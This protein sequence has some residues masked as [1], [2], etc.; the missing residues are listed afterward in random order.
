MDPTIPAGGRPRRTEA[1]EISRRDAVYTAIARA[2]G[3]HVQHIAR[4]TGL[5][6]RG[7]L[8][9]A[10]ALV[11]GG[12]LVEH[13][14]LRRR[15]FPARG[16][17]G[18]SDRDLVG[19]IREPGPLAVVLV[20]LMEGPAS[21]ARMLQACTLARSSLFHHLLILEGEGVVER[22]RGIAALCEPHRVALLLRKYPPTPD[23]LRHLRVDHWSRE[24][25]AMWQA[26]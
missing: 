3:S 10:Q 9:H 15:F 22:V 26:R 6:P 17:P 23:E 12:I 18:R 8:H 11:A 1:R 4:G 19:L 14:G 2:P 13:K 21:P 16:G 24:Q 20:L 5:T 7:V 25:L